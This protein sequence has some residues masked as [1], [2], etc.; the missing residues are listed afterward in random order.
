MTEDKDIQRRKRK[1]SV[2]LRDLKKVI[3]MMKKAE[4]SELDIEQEG[5]TLRLRKGAEPMVMG[6]MQ[7]APLAPQAPASSQAPAAPAAAPAPAAEAP[8]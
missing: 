4:L 5:R 8:S 7:P 3:D 1:P 6:A 2:N